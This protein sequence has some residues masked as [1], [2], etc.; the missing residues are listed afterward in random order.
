MIKRKNLKTLVFALA[1]SGAF[2][3]ASTSSAVTEAGD[4]GVSPAYTMS[5]GIMETNSEQDSEALREAFLRAGKEDSPNAFDIHERSETC[6]GCG[7]FGD[8]EPSE[9]TASS[10]ETRNMASFGVL[11]KKSLSVFNEHERSSP[12]E[13]CECMPGTECSGAST[14]PSFD[15]EGDKLACPPGFKP[16]NNHDGCVPASGS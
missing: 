15:D 1:I 3:F 8:I 2:G 9:G 4:L 11:G 12:C 7:T 14:M 13:E 5:S 10:S 6:E 16:N